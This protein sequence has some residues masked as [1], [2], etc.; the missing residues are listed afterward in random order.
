MFDS[1][2][3]CRGGYG[4]LATIS[5]QMAAVQNVTMFWPAASPVW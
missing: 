1:T 4:V 2:N 5:W 3:Q